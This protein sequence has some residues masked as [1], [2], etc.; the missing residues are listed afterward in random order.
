VGAGGPAFTLT[1]NG[2]NYVNASA[3]Q[4][5]GSSRTTTF[6]SGTQL[7]ASISAADIV[8]AGTATVTV[9]NPA[10]GGGT[11]NVVALTINGPIYFAQFGNGGNF[12]SSI[13]IVNPSGTDTANG[14]VSLLDDQGLP[15]SVSFNNQPPSDKVAF[16]IKPLGTA[17]FTSDGL[18]SVV[19]GSA[20]V[21][22]SVPVAGVIR[23]SAPGLGIAGVGESVPLSVLMTPIERN[24][25]RGLN[26]GI[27][28]TNTQTIPLQ[29]ALS[30]RGLDGVEINFGSA[31]LTLPSGGHLA[32]FVDELFTKADT[33]N[34]LGTLVVTVITPNGKIS[35]TA[36]QL[37]ANPGEFTTL[38]VV[39]IE[40]VP[41]NLQLFFA[42]YGNGGGF[43]SSL[44]LTNPLSLSI[45]GS[46]TFFDDNGN[47]LSV[48]INGQPASGK[49][50]FRI[51]PKGGAVF[52]T[53]GQ[54][55]LIAGSARVIA[56]TFSGSNAVG[57][58]LRFS[59]PGSGI[60]GVGGVVLPTSGF[61][62]PATRSTSGNFSTGVAITSNF[63]PATLTLTLRN[64][65]GDPV[66]GGQVTQQLPANGHLAKF[67]QE[68]FPTADTREFEGTL[69]VTASG[70]TVAGTAIQLGSKPGEFTTLPVSPLR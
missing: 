35:A 2:T 61:I 8:A 27:A 31:S 18:G 1:V 4:W 16:T 29:L 22:A 34:F 7:T 69:T 67:I 9:S 65:N 37:G 33:R 57:G 6:V 15:L 12:I 13:V 20:R 66:T 17:S 53:D 55:N 42:Q 44:F 52:T 43:I 56:F 38:P 62:I 60:A 51:P 39:P 40:P 26:T 49:A 47:P 59:A 25:V 68:L 11:S 48:S 5:N 70:A 58:V 10:P 50:A 14:S 23:F 54:G 64:K 19:I 36:L 24:V 21:S 63:L 45:D 3:V 28:V 46:V 41:T 32:K 30:L